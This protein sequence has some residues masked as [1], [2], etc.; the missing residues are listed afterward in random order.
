MP[1]V[2]EPWHRRLLLSGLPSFIHDCQSDMLLALGVFARG[3]S[4]CCSGGV[5]EMFILTNHFTKAGLVGSSCVLGLFS[6]CYTFLEQAGD[7]RVDGS[8]SP[9]GLLNASRHQIDVTTRRLVVNVLQSD[10]ESS[11]RYV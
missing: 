7:T 11:L 2:L 4:E 10:G 3:T 6:A 5:Y 9:M 1:P 8:R